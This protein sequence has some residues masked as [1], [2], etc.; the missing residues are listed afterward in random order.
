MA[1]TASGWPTISCTAAPVQP[2]TGIWECWTMLAAL[3]EATHRVEIG[4][5]GV[6]QFLP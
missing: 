3:A 1:S 2:T 5:A 6:V 4:S